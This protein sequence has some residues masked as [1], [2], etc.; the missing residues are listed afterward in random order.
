[1]ALVV[2]IAVLALIFLVFV[3]MFTL[4]TFTPLWGDDWWRVVPLIDFF[5]IFGRIGAEYMSWGGRV[6]VLLLTFLSFLKYPGSVFLFNMV[7]SVMFCLLLVFIFRGASGHYPGRRRGDLALLG[8]T[9]FSVWFFTQ[10]LGEAVLW[11]T[12]A[13]GYLWVLTAAVFIVTP[14]VDLVVRRYPDDNSPWR[15]WGLPVVVL[16]WATG[17]ENVSISLVLFMI[18]T[19][20]AAYSQKV[21]IRRWYWHVFASQLLGTIILISAPGNWVRAAGSSDGKAIYFRFLSLCQVIWRHVT[22]Q[23]PI[24]Y[25]VA[26]L[27]LVFIIFRPRASLK[28]FYLWLVL[29]LT[30]ALSMSGSPGVNFENRTA[31]AANIGFIVAM[32]SL[33][34]PLVSMAC[35]R[36]WQTQILLLPVYAVLMG[37]LTAD[38]M[39]TMEQYLSVWHQTQ[40]RLEL[41]AD[42][43]DRGIREILLP[44]MKIPYIEGL[45]DNIVQ[46]RFFLRDLHPNVDGNGWRNGTYAAYYGFSFANR[47]TVP[48][49]LYVP[50]LENG[51]RFTSLKKSPQLS[52]YLRR[53][54]R[55]LG[56]RNVIYCVN[57]RRPHIRINEIRAYPKNRGDL[58]PNER[59]TGYRTI[60]V[61]ND[62]AVALI[63]ENCRQMAG[64]VISRLELPDWDVERIEMHNDRLPWPHFET[65]H[66][67]AQDSPATE[68]ATTSGRLTWKGTELQYSNAAVVDHGRG[69][70][71]APGGRVVEGFLNWGPYVRLPAGEYTFEFEYAAQG[72]GSR[73]EI[74]AQT[75]AG[76]RTLASGHL[77][78][79]GDT[80]M[81]FSGN[82]S[83]AVDLADDPIEF[84]IDPVDRGRVELVRFTVVNSSGQSDADF[85]PSDFVQ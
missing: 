59:R 75:A 12:G 76:Q 53:E 32:L 55:G 28:R 19:L 33:C 73:W 61:K 47:V 46:G 74:V 5:H 3:L 50:E 83:V 52:I 71:T 68:G 60:G 4:N 51:E 66:L 85:V 34:S 48:Y 54:A 17:L 64:V 78:P 56:T 67:N 35:F 39:K 69:T 80:P 2:Q 38:V 41:M 31:F 81:V 77:A 8:F 16:L 26:A 62:S 25:A 72:P 42:Y 40:R 9:L 82:F 29:G 21:T 22:T 43:K 15:L 23:V 1:M 57:R 20:L 63:S 84:R 44:S 37:L 11:K 70:I 49:L 18:F 24:L 79:H 65:F 10:C 14:F 30:L 6:W 13:V 45:H 27:L 7:N 36:K 58:S